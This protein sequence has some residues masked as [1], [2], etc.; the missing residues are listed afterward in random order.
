[1]T[2]T[3]TE[4]NAIVSYMQ[5]KIGHGYSEALS[6]PDIRFGPIDFDCSGLV[7]DAMKAAGINIPQSDAIASSEANWLGSNGAQVIKSA[8]Q[9]QNGDIVFF[10]GAAP[11][12]SNYGPIG[13]VGVALGNGNYVSAYDTAKGVTTTPVAGDHFV[14]AMRLGP[15]G[16][17]T[18]PASDNSGGIISWPTDITGFFSDADHFVTALM[19][20]AKPGSW[21]RIVA[22]LAGIILLLFAIH[23]LIA[24][25]NGE[26]IVQ[27]P[28]VVPIP[29]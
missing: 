8:S 26:P 11:D 15:G 3:S 13:H 2:F 29:V 10:T 16:T 28:K 9:L 17:G 18:A 27:A 12:P 20:I 25:A 4:A 5:S 14:V 19:W 21:V 23:S 1:M 24:A 6:G 7:Y 22:F